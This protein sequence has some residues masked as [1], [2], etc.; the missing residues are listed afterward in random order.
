MLR[1]QMNLLITTKWHKHT[2]TLDF[3]RYSLD[4]SE[5][6]AEL[7]KNPTIAWR[8]YNLKKGINLAT[9]CTSRDRLLYYISV[10]GKNL[11]L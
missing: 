2:M 7:D 4:F 6:S 11:K 3:V 9:Y 10:S 1:Q 5:S 8:E